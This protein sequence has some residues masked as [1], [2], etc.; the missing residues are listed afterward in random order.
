MA[1]RQIVGGIVEGVLSL[2]TEL[3]SFIMMV[4]SKEHKAIHDHIAGT[5]VL[6]DPNGVLAKK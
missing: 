2:V 1:L 4:S 3:I 6:D 5:I